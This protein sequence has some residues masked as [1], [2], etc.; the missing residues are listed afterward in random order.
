MT[1]NVF[2]TPNNAYG[3]LR[4]IIEAYVFGQWTGLPITPPDDEVNFKKR[5]LLKFHDFLL[6]GV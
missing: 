3:D 1:G 5:F 6:L 4:G 2:F